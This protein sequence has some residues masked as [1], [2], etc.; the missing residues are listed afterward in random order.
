MKQTIAVIQ[1][2]L[3]LDL[4]V[5][6]T[7]ANWKGHVQHLKMDAGNWQVLIP[8]EPVLTNILSMHINVMCCRYGF[9]LG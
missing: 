7:S 5:M 3:F 4:S 1:N 2:H 9:P 8:S 6:V